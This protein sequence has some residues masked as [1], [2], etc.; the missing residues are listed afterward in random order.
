MKTKNVM[1]ALLMLQSG[2]VLAG[3]LLKRDVWLAIV[4]YWAI[5]LMKNASDYIDL[6]RNGHGRNDND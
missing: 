1:I 2:L 5:L 6:K 3:L 4:C